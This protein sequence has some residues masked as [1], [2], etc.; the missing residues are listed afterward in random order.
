MPRAKN[1][2]HLTGMIWVSFLFHALFLAVFL[3]SPS[4]PGKKW[5]FGP[6]YSVDLVNAPVDQ[7]NS[8]PKVP[9]S[10]EL[11]SI[12]PKDQIPVKKNDENTL[13]YLKKERAL[14]TENKDEAQR[15]AAIDRMR[16]QLKDS[17][18]ED[19][20]NARAHSGGLTA[21]PQ[22]GS[23]Q[24]NSQLQA[25]CGRIEAQIRAQWALPRGIIP[26]QNLL[27]VIN[28]AILKDGTLSGLNFEKG[29]GNKYFD[30]S[31]ERAIRKASPFPPLPD[32][33][34]DSSLEIG[35]RF[36]SNYFRR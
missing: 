23:G 10:Q 31:A 35:I 6:V 2:L 25:Y 33:V 3:L 28:I 30:Q 5:T 18:S 19:K 7:I 1:S 15:E 29:S 11:S 21:L 32:G 17:A 24:L 34:N 22:S 27:A 4:L 12:R 16:K 14:K 13:N 8:Q 36:P 26:E 20:K 9:L